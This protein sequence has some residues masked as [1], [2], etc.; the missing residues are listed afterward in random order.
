MKK[1][2][3]YIAVAALGFLGCN[4]HED[5]LSRPMSGSMKRWQRISRP[6]LQHNMAGKG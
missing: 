2:F 4:K 1:S 6:L 5:A 3:L